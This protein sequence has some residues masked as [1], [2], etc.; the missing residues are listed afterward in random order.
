MSGFFGIVVA[1][2]GGMK[3]TGVDSIDPHNSLKLGNEKAQPTTYA[4][5]NT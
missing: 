1:K 4:R 2:N 3:R 5:I